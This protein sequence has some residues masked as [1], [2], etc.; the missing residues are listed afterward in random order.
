[1]NSFTEQIVA[2]NLADRIFTERQLAA[3]VGDSDARRYGLVNR[4]LKEGSLIR[5]K[6][7]IYMLGK[8]NRPEAF[9]PFTVAQALL[10]GSYISF[11]TA[12]AFH[13]WIPEAV[14]TTAS[15][16]PQRKT[17]TVETPNMGSFIFHPL[18]IQEYQFLTN[19]RREKFGGL[20]AFVA[21]PSRALMDL[22]ALRKQVWS[23][24]DW[25]TSG[26][27]IDTEQLLSLRRKDFVALN[28]VYKHKTANKF[29]QGFENA[30]FPQKLLSL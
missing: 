3:L 4:A 7:G 27:R 26:M 30:L 22:V 13:G 17:L 19:V 2:A 5:L 10:P 16:T 11:E 29:L 21:T 28:L 6:R 23:D 1:M 20:T 9:H 18:A 15:V 8:R 24:L 14:Y 25:L 12:L